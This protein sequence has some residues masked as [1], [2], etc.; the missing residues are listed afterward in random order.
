[1]FGTHIGSGI[2]SICKILEICGGGALPT[3]FIKMQLDLFG[4]KTPSDRPEY[5]EVSANMR[6]FDWSRT[7]RALKSRKDR[8][9]YYGIYCFYNIASVLKIPNAFWST[10]RTFEF[11]SIAAFAK[12]L[13]QGAISCHTSSNPV[14]RFLKAIDPC[15]R[16]VC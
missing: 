12:F 2:V 16:S 11:R 7:E 6:R 13:A 10:P 8:R 1:M 5:P 14:D 4:P 3:P 15:C 9:H